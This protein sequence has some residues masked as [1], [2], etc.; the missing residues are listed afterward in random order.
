LSSWISSRYSTKSYY[1]KT[2][3]SSC[4]NSWQIRARSYSSIVQELSPL[5]RKL[6]LDWYRLDQM[7]YFI[8]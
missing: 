3:S 1:S 2:I 8:S 4:I 5:F 6:Q 7:R